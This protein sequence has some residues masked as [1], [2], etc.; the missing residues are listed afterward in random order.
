MGLKTEREL[1]LGIRA[2]EIYFQFCRQLWHLRQL[3]YI[4]LYSHLQCSHAL[5]VSVNRVQALSFLTKEVLKSGN[6]YLTR[7][8]YC[9]ADTVTISHRCLSLYRRTHPHYKDSEVS[10]HHSPVLLLTKNIP[11]K[12]TLNIWFLETINIHTVRRIKNVII[13]PSTIYLFWYSIKAFI[14]G[15][16]IFF[17]I[18]IVH[19][20][21]LFCRQKALH[22]DKYIESTWANLQM[23]SNKVYL[24]LL[25]EQ[26][27]RV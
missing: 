9:H 19:K 25:S 21:F 10:I 22:P 27:N 17:L 6:L 12:L 8:K 18:V 24:S 7:D 4:L 11:V 1:D 13:F 23:Q 2:P 14:V 15:T 20:H 3:I 26:S 5:A 16:L